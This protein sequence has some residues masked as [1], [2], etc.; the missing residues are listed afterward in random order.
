[1]R[2]YESNEFYIHTAMQKFKFFLDSKRR[3]IRIMLM[4]REILDFKA[5]DITYFERIFGD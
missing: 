2:Q 4:S 3:G 5:R 1:M